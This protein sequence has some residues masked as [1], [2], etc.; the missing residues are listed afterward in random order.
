MLFLKVVTYFKKLHTPYDCGTTQYQL[1]KWAR[2]DQEKMD[3][4][5]KFVGNHYDSNYK[6]GD[7]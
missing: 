5:L 3:N 6:D 7:L 1:D 4:K 2:E